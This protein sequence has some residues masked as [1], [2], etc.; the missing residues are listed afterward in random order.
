[1]SNSSTDPIE[2]LK[3]IPKGRIRHALFDFDGTI[4]LIR[5]GWQSVMHSMMVDLICGNSEPSPDIDQEIEDFIDETTGIQTIVQMQSL[6]D[7]IRRFGFVADNDVLDAT[8]YKA[9]YNERLMERVSVRRHQLKTGSLL[10]EDATVRGA[11]NFIDALST[12]GVRLCIFSGTDRDDVKEEAQLLG[13]ADYFDEITGS[14]GDYAA[15][16]KERVIREL[17]AE[18]DL[19]GPEVLVVGDGPVE[20]RHGSAFGCTTIGVASDEV[21]RSGWDDAKRARLIGAGV[22]ALVSDF[23]RP[24]ELLSLLEF[25]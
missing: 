18:H 13:V 4:S 22:H 1:M 6:A 14:V 25:K 7:M 20:I 2:I 19:S 15:Y 10:V 21:N 17:M 3:E 23:S 24:D 11:I 8:A 9:I 12:R 16:N 5:E